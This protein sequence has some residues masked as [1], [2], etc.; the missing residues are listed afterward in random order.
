M[1]PR[2][3]GRRELS[4]K[5]TQT[6]VTVR[7]ST[8][9]FYS[10][11]TATTLRTHA[12][13]D[14]CFTLLHLAPA[15]DCRYSRAT[16]NPSQ[17]CTSVAAQSASNPLRLRLT[18]PS[19]TTFRSKTSHLNDPERLHAAHVRSNT[20]LSQS[21]LERTVEIITR[22]TISKGSACD[23]ETIARRI[24]VSIALLRFAQLA[25]ALSRPSKEN[26]IAS[27]INR[28]EL[29]LDSIGRVS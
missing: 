4:V 2:I 8:S 18:R 15:I 29:R 22:V 25:T 24:S 26:L 7:S 21:C 16:A 3:P 28:L 17:L 14:R 19:P 1:T 12:L 13:L 23:L 27:S 11:A 9:T 20:H 5:S 6:C 10:P